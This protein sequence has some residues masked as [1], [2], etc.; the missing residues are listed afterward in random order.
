MSSKSPRRRNSNGQKTRRRPTKKT[1]AKNSDKKTEPVDPKSITPNVQADVVEVVSS[2]KKTKETKQEAETAT[3]PVED[4]VEEKKNQQP[5]VKVVED[6]KEQKEQKEQKQA[7]TEAETTPKIIPKSSKP[8]RMVSLKRGALFGTTSSP[9]SSLSH[10]GGVKC[11]AFSPDGKQ[12]AAGDDSNVLIVRDVSSGRTTCS[13]K[14]TGAVWGCAFSPDGKYVCCGDASGRHSVFDVLTK[15]KMTEILHPW[16]ER[17]ES[18]AQVGKKT[19]RQDRARRS[20]KRK[21]GK[22]KKLKHKVTILADGTKSTTI[23]PEEM[24]TSMGGGVAYTDDGKYCAIG[25]F[26]NKVHLLDVKNKYR[27]M[28]S[29]A[30]EGGVFGVDIGG[31]TL[32]ATADLSGEKVILRSLPSLKVQHVFD[33]TDDVNCVAFTKNAKMIAAGDDGFNVIVRECDSGSIV[34]TFQYKAPINSIS[35]SFDDLNLAVCGADLTVRNVETGDITLL[36]PHAN[37]LW[38][39]DFSPCNRIIAAV[40]DARTIILRDIL[41]DEF[42][43]MLYTNKNTQME[44]DAAER[45]ATATMGKDG[46]EKDALTSVAAPPVSAMDVCGGKIVV[47]SKL[48]TMIVSTKTGAPSMEFVTTKEIYRVNCVALSSDGRLLAIGDESGRIVVR[49]VDTDPAKVLF[50]IAGSNAESPTPI[51]YIVFSPGLT[52]CSE[53]EQNIN[54]LGTSKGI[55]LLAS[56]DAQNRI[57]VRGLNTPM[58]ELYSVDTEAGT[59]ISRES[60]ISSLHFVPGGSDLKICTTDGRDKVTFFSTS[61]DS[62]TLTVSIFGSSDVLFDCVVASSYFSI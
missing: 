54:P 23:S 8:K 33:H 3:R 47:A 32:L 30:H 7:T 18:K 39:C 14:L 56:S 57:V 55:A 27:I 49:V 48:S 38:S 24:R 51:K 41:T 35:F 40:D 59:S 1:T 9:C 11:V 22:K 37:K 36:Y 50:T 61:A 31:S 58:V 6:K 16:N 25:D 15:T 19:I 46:N 17:E 21:K 62:N 42:E 4:I 45:K 20:N 12:I 52:N 29:I 26:T 2:T 28:A 10:N 60:G 43:H 53:G 34:H 13:A 44:Q 5:A